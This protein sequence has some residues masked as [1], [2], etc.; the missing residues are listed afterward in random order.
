MPIDT[1][2]FVARPAVYRPPLDRSARLLVAAGISL[3]GD[4]LTIIALAVFLFRL[5]HRPEA[6]ALY[7]LA[8]L[9]PRVL[10]PILG[11]SLADRYGPGRV[12][13]WSALGQCVLTTGVFFAATT[14]TMWAV[15]VAVG[16]SSF[17][18]A[19][20]QPGYS[21][22]IPRVTDKP[23]LLRVNAIYSALF[24]SSVLV[25][26]ALGA[27]LLPIVKPE[28]L[29]AADAVSFVLASVLVLSLRVGPVPREGSA[30][31][32]PDRPLRLV[33]RDPVLRALG[34]SFFW[35]SAAITAL[36]AV[37]VV[38]AARRF[39]QDTGVGWLYAS[40]GAGGV[41]GSLLLVR[42]RPPPIRARGIAVGFVIGVVPLGLFALVG[43]LLPAL[44]LLF[45]STA[46]EAIYQTRG[47]TAM[48]QIV[49]AEMLGRVN[50]VMRL[51]V[52]SGMLVGAVAPVALVEPI[53]WPALVA[54]AAAV[55]AVAFFPSAV[56]YRRGTPRADEV[57]LAGTPAALRS[58][59]IATA[60]R[61]A[62]SVGN[63][64]ESPP[65]RHDLS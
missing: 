26:P 24:E 55:S 5:T 33:A 11:G 58:D 9:A 17:L 48:Q 29:V 64:T 1:G 15:L 12:A 35:S 28:A 2:R 19:V 23:R 7:I 52:Y 22:C 18:G 30:V 49:P 45:L 54:G 13:G 20:A 43:A 41:A 37:L 14:G 59:Q 42:W 46:S 6:P 60:S 32:A 47:Q 62:F 63:S 4:W 50:G 21:A 44:G 61:P 8:R 36:Q 56:P 25:A 40:V 51:L 34:A 27:L 16:G 38:A 57:T 53:G 3:Y 31:G 39:G 65:S 10:V